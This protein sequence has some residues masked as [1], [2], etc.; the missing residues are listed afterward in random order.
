MHA[1]R[2]GRIPP[3]LKLDKGPDVL[4]DERHIDVL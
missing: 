3:E 4:L 2:S 1:D